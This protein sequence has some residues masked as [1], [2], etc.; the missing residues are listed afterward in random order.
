MLGST[1]ITV[2]RVLAEIEVVRKS[3]H[4]HSVCVLCNWPADK[5]EFHLYTQHP[6]EVEFM[7]LMGWKCKLFVEVNTNCKFCTF[8]AHSRRSLVG[9]IKKIHLKAM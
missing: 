7:Q 4:I 1:K 8:V 2:P 9:H 5:K 3:T 6:D